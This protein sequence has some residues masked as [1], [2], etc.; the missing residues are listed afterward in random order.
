MTLTAERGYLAVG[1]A[2]IAAA[3]DMSLAELRALYPG[4]LAML[5]AFSRQIDEAVLAGGPAEGEGARDRLLKR[6]ARAARCSPGLATAL[7][8]IATS[9]QRWML[10]AAGIHRSGLPWHVAVDGSVVVLAGTL[11]VWLDD[12]DADMARTMK[13]L[14]R[15]LDRGDRAMRLLDDVCGFFC[16]LA[17]RRGASETRVAG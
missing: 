5:A 4:K 1:L 6:L 2:D 17:P 14:D 8:C 12:D 15:A 7:L 3:A 10:A 16:R 13:A 9:S 11:S